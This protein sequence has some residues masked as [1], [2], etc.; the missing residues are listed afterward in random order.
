MRYT[1]WESTVPADL[2]ADSLWQRQDYRLSLYAADLGW[3]D[4]RLLTGVRA[5]ADVAS[6]LGRALGSISANIA[7]GYARSSGNDRARFY[8]YALGSARESRDWYHKS[9]HVLGA[10][11]VRHRLK[12]LTSVVRLLTYAIPR[13]RGTSLTDRTAQGV[14]EAR[15]TPWDR[16]TVRPLQQQGTR[17]DRD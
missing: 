16:S 12:V 10:P 4:I 17:N 2:T 14:G 11:V 13:E 5:T 1:E 15:P 8:E 7:E 6:Q 3:D 9:R